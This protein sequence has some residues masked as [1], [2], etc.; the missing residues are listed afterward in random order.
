MIWSFSLGVLGFLVFIVAS[1]R[2]YWLLERLT[3]Y[4]LDISPH[5]SPGAGD[6]L[7]AQFNYMN[8]KNYRAEGLP[9][10]RRLYWTMLVQGM[11]ALLC[12]I[13]WI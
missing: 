13:A 11:G 3:E 5:E 7:F 2:V 1:V 12:V 9:G 10:L 4:R 8:P 6:S